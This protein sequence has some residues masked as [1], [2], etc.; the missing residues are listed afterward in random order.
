PWL[1]IN[2]KAETVNT[3]SKSLTV[4]FDQLIYF[5]T[6]HQMSRS[7]TRPV[8]ASLCRVLY[9]K[10]D[11]TFAAIQPGDSMIIVSY[12]DEAKKIPMPRA[13]VSIENQVND[14][15]SPIIADEI[16]IRVK[17]KNK[18]KEG[19]GKKAKPAE[20]KK[21]SWQEIIWLA[22]K[23]LIGLLIFVLLL[24]VIYLLYCL[25]RISISG[26]TITKANQVYRA[27]LYRFHMVG[28]EREDETPLEYAQHKVDA[29]LSAGFEEFMRIYLRL[30]YAN[31]NLRDGDGEE[32]D[33]FATNIGSSIRRKIGIP[34]MI[35]NYL[36]V[37]RASR[38]IQPT[39]KADY[40]N[41]LL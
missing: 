22:G 7:F 40:E 18:R 39:P 12:K 16:H 36:N 1:V 29:T 25:L 11:T 31:G 13:G 9:D 37:L 33:R 41:Q 15:P 8:D 10:R 20:E 28:L 27:A 2:G 3:S 26:N 32:I 5:N 19:A 4:S 34:K 24:P 21:M 30:K 23:V 38:Y 6:P 14:F 35:L 17:E